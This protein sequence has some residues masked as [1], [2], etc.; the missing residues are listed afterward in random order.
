MGKEVKWQGWELL[1]AVH[2]R[3]E[4]R[5]GNGVKNIHKSEAI[6]K[7]QRNAFRYHRNLRCLRHQG[8]SWQISLL[9]IIL[10]MKYPWHQSSRWLSKFMT[11]KRESSSWQKQKCCVHF[12]M[13]RAESVQRIAGDIITC[14]FTTSIEDTWEILEKNTSLVH[15]KQNLSLNLKCLRHCH[16]VPNG[17]LLTIIFK[18]KRNDPQF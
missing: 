13:N 11:V 7:N 1:C 17:S 2:R 8:F 4:R 18:G 12:Q 6:P 16:P 10:P 5:W 3:R 9:L 15:G 14:V